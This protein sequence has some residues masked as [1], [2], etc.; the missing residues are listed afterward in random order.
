MI[1][2]KIQ[3]AGYSFDDVLLV[4]RKGIL[5]RRED[6]DISTR[7]SKGF[8]LDIPIISAPMSSVTDHRMAN[9]MQDAGG[10]GILHRFYESDDEQLEAFLSIPQPRRVGVAV[11]LKTNLG[12]INT[13][14]E[15]GCQLLC[16]DVAHGDNNSVL[17]AVEN[18]K[19]TFP[20]IDLI[21]GNV[22]TPDGTNRLCDAGADAIKVGIGPGA[23]CTTREVTG[24]GVPQLTAIEWCA[25]MAR[26]YDV[27]IIADGGIKNSGDIVKALAAGADSVMLGRLLA[28]SDEAPYPGEYF[29]MASKRVNG[30]NAPEGID[31]TVERTGPVAETLKQLTWGLKSGI[32]YAGATN[33]EELRF[34]AE[35]MSISSG[36][37][38]E[39]GTRL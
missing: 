7:L 24:F 20:H 10:I 9:A 35:F 4:P 36:T 17:L 15:F 6:A 39:S 2:L 14:S 37:Y 16:L 19:L 13:L 22:A 3:S 28:G 30:H 21:V 34:Q 23:V 18:L 38:I 33:L 25:N 11:G 32:S 1:N 5:H 26:G 12:H 27:P 8:D 29:G 31:G